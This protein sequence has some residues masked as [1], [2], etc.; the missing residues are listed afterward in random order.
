MPDQPKTPH[1]SFR[2][3]PDLKERAATK[4]A[5]EG[6]TLTDVIVEKLSEYVMPSPPRQ[7]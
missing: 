4:A 5:G 2:L 7:Q 6:R 3:P 1:S